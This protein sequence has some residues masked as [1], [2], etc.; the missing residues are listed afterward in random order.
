MDDM[1]LVHRDADLLRVTVNR[2]DKRNPLSRRVLALIHDAF[3]AVRDDQALRAAIVT[4]AGDRC[5]A[6][7][8]DLRELDEVRSHADALAF[9]DEAHAALD[10]VRRCPVPV[11]AALNGDALGGGAELAVACDLRVMAAGARIGFI[12]GRLNIP[13][14]W[15]GAADLMRLVGPA[16][17]L[18]LLARSAAV[19]GA[20]ALAIGLADAVAA[21]GES[22]GDAVERFVAPMRRQCPRVLRAFKAQAQAD[23]D[24]LPRAERRAAERAAFADAWVH[25]DHWAAAA[26][27]LRTIGSP[28]FPA[29]HGVVAE[30]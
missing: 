5:F 30:R 3:A 23:R 25:D 9:S 1:V 29:G 22:F 20:E 6:A 16:R 13:T 4:G 12:Q 26:T 24:G 8:G 19:G 28:P 27:A 18:S 17:G 21:D 10:A 2:P 11:V 7:G 15:G 14:S